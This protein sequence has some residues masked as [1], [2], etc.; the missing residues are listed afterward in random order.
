MKKLNKYT[1]LSNF[2]RG[3]YIYFLFFIYLH[4]KKYI[5]ITIIQIYKK[6]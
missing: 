6:N 3:E 5:I 4:N 1:Y 2:K